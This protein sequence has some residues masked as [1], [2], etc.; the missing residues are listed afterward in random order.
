M[1]L[2]RN[3]EERTKKGLFSK[4][5]L[6]ILSLR[7]EM[8]QEELALAKKYKFEDV[9]TIRALRRIDCEPDT[10][11]LEDLLRGVEVTCPYAEVVNSIEE[12]MHDNLKAMRQRI[13]HY[14]DFGG[15]QVTSF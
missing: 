1:Q 3:V 9:A 6:F 2:F 10:I 8:T 14:K 11:T 13:D 4:K 12:M 7:I 15:E 5:T